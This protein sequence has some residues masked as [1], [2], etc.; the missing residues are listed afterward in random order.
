LEI[1]VPEKQLYCS[2]EYIQ[3]MLCHITKDIFSTRFIAVLFITA[4]NWKQQTCPSTKTQKWIQTIW[5]IY[6]TECYSAIK[7]KG[8]T[9]FAGK[10]IELKHIILSEET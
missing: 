8:I 7:N 4:R 10:W 6:T 3:K 1:V 5:F 9:K 2:W